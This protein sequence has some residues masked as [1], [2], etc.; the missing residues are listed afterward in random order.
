MGTEDGPNRV[1]RG[2]ANRLQRQ[3]SVDAPN[4]HWVTDITYVRTYEGWLFAVWQRKSAWGLM[5]HSD[6]GS[7]FTG[8]DGK[9]FLK[10]L[11]IASAA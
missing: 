1:D 7:Q 11:G 2:G 9:V 3:F 4:I 10:A 6:Q 8:G 5:L